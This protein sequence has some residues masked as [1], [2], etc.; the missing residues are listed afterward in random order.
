MP[1]SQWKG[2]GSGYPKVANATIKTYLCPSDTVGGGTSVID[3]QGFNTHAPSMPGGTWA[4][5]TVYNIPNYGRELG[6]ANYVGVAGA[7]A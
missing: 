5:D 7:K 2:T 6:R 4:V 1:P 3:G